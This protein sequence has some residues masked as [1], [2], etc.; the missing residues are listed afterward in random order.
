MDATVLDKEQA[1]ARHIPREDFRPCAEAFVDRRN[2]NSEGKLNYSFIGPGVA[3]S[4][5]QEVNIVEAHGFN[6]GGVSLP[7][8]RVNNLHLHFT[9][10]VFASA[11]GEW[12]FIWGNEGEGSL[13]FGRRDVFTIPT[14]IYR[15][16]Y[17]RGGD[18]AFMFA[19]IGN[20]DPGGIVW[21]P[22]VL[23]DAAAAG[24]RLSETN[25]VIDESAGERLPAGEGYIEPMPAEEMGRLPTYTPEQAERYV[26]RWD[27]L[28]WRD[29]ALP[30]GGRLA[31]V[32]GHG[33][34]ASRHHRPRVAHPH[35]FSIEWL[36]LAPGEETGGWLEGVPMV[37]FVFD[38]EPTVLVNGEADREEVSL[39]TRSIYSV[40]ANAWRGFRNGGGAE[41]TLMLVHGGDERVRPAW[42]GAAQAAAAARGL[43]LDPD[44]FLA[45]RAALLP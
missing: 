10:E 33:M 31:T 20:D 5:S 19:V 1:R 11:D 34:T 21:N 16:F 39:A 3:Q 7:P 14:W 30:G 4:D 43:A 18:D 12:E 22:K 8:G 36:S 15:G 9:A 28:D 29:D 35:S 42:D 17:N 40:P 38:G 27:G 32:L 25:R 26:I 13:A 23:E 6:V 44:G 45:P 41:A 2:P 24:I 37:A